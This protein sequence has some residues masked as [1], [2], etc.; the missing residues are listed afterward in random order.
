MPDT[1]NQGGGGGPTQSTVMNTNIPEYA[2]PY[3]ESMLGATQQQLFNTQQVTDPTTGQNT[4]QIT[5]VKG[6]TPFG[7]AGA[8]MGPTE[9]A[10]AQAAVA[11]FSPLQQQA[12]QG[13]AGLQMP[14]Q[15]GAATEAAMM[16]TQAALGAGQY[17]PG[18]FGN[19]FRAPAAYRP[20]QFSMVQAQAPELTQYQ[21]GGPERVGA[22]GMEAAQMQAAQTGY[23]PDLQTFQMAGP[24]RVRTQSFLR[25]G[26]SEAYMSPYMQ[27]VVDA[28][29]REAIRQSGIA[30]TQL[31]GQAT[32]A[33]AFGGARYGLMEA[34]RQRNLAT[35]LGDIQATGLQSAFQQ[36]QQ[37][38]NA[39]Q[40]ARLQA[41]L[42]N[43]QA[44]LQVGG[45]NLAAALGVQQLGTQ[46]G[47]QTALANLTNQ[48]QAA[49]QNQAAQLQA[50]GMNAQQAMQ[51]ALAN[52][53]A[54]L[55]VGQQNLGAL[56]GIQQ[57]GAGQNLQAQLANQ[58]ALQA[59]Q[60][61]AEQSRQYGYGQAM[62]AAQQ[63]AQYGL[64]GQQAEEQSRQFGAGLGLQGAQTGLQGAGQLAN[65]GSQQLGAQQGIL[66][67]QAQTGQQQ[68]QQQQNVINQ[69]LQNYATTQQYPQQQLAFMNAMLR[70]LPLQTATTQ[71]YQAA[72]SM[73][74]QL[75]GL[76]LAG[77]GMYGLANRKKGGAIKE[78]K[79]KAPAGLAEL[80]LMKM[81]V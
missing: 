42:A 51:A 2:R 32:Q 57:L 14:G 5:G 25:P 77:A 72:P 13:I 60:Q 59:A 16:G 48:Q 69:M 58:Q 6:Y 21:M 62:T 65:I 39:E 70:G 37:Q 7:A 19:Q 40:Q 49:V 64:A 17:Q 10:A 50:Q 18:Y 56:L 38:F 15:F 46:T 67:L 68:Q 71:S 31:A 9:Q 36:A 45:Q 4:T 43:Q 53:Q 30:G 47:L 80:A 44:G 79:D 8:G 33:G 12:Q 34:E 63:R 73:T 28:Q 26:T 20:G 74:S 24:E 75:T 81:G 35:Q 11:G 76:G 54:G 52:Q 61:A 1:G 29:Q 27:S 78:P 22:P 23:R 41:S 66:G 3:V 55:T